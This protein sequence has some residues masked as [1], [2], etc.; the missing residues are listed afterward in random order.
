MSTQPQKTPQTLLASAYAMR[1]PTMD[2]LEAAVALFN[3]CSQALVGV[4][5]F[6]LDETRT[7]WSLPGFDLASDARLLHAPDGE[8]V[9][10]I[11]VWDQQPHV[12]PYVWGRVHPEHR[13]RGL[14]TRLLQWAE[15]RARQAVPKA[16]HGARVTLLAHL[17]DRDHHA[18]NLFIACGFRLVRHSFRMEIEMTAP[19]PAPHWP[20]GLDGRTPITLTT[21][22]AGE[23]RQVVQAVREAFKDHW[24]HVERPFEEM[25]ARWTHWMETS[26]DFDPTLWFIARDG[27]QIAGMSLCAPKAPGYPGMGW[28]DTLGVRRPWRRRGLGLALLHHTFGEFYRRGYRQVGLDVDAASLTGATRLYKKAGM[29][30][31]RRYDLFEKELR[32]GEEFSTQTLTTPG[33]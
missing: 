33:S 19:P 17:L 22:R 29:H 26:E 13:G 12:R 28:V 1:A 21:L 11:E 3:R 8:L 10:Y 32:P 7:E 5:E 30:V 24:G 18:H 9:G 27:D 14:G 25:V 16:P 6:D 20:P 23:E 4:R 15:E 2:D 31:A